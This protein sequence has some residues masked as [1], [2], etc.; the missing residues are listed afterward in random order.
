MPV[1]NLVQS[2]WGW[3]CSTVCGAGAWLWNDTIVASW[4]YVAPHIKVF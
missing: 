3:G 2:V 4:N 1:V